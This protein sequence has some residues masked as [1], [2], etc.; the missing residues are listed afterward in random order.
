MGK[1]LSLFRDH[2]VED[3]VYMWLRLQPKTFFVDEIRMILNLRTVH[4][5][6]IDDYIET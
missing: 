2:K 1:H 5:E 3:A 6:R 4:V